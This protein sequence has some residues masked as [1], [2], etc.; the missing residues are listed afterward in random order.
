MAH[1]NLSDSNRFVIEH[2]LGYCWVILPAGIAAQEYARIE[3]G[4]DKQLTG[5]KDRVVIDFSNVSAL[6]S[7]GLGILIRIQKKIAHGGGVMALV[8]VSQ[9]VS[10]LLVS[11]HLDKIFPL[12][13]TDVEFEISQDELWNRKISAQKVHFLFIAQVERNIY[14]ITLSGEMVQG[15]DMSACKK[16]TPDPKV[17]QWMLDLSSLTALDSSGAGVF[18]QL[19]QRIVRQGGTCRAFGAANDVRQVLHFLG[20]EQFITFFEK[21]NEALAGWFASE[22]S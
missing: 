6:Y 4:I 22:G 8:N 7:S 16:F 2:R 3:D 15:H 10:D 12:Y 11:L 20:A 1:E 17:N 18:M 19:L 5:K 14:R 13:S 21:E 9:K